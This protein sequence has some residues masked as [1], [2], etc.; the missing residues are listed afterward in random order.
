MNSVKEK[1]LGMRW[2][3]IKPGKFFDHVARKGKYLD[4]L[5]LMALLSV[6]I[7]IGLHTI[8][9]NVTPGM[10][11]MYAAQD[12]LAVFAALVVLTG[13]WGLFSALIGLRMR[14]RIAVAI[15]FKEA[16]P[17]C[18]R[19]V[20]FALTPLALLI[21]P[22]DLC[23]GLAALT[24]LVFSIV[25][26]SKAL[27]LKIMPSMI[28]NVIVL[29]SIIGA[30]WFVIKTFFVKPPSQPRQ[31]TA[32]EFEAQ[33]AAKALIGKPA[34]DI[35]I[36]PTGGTPL[37]LSDLKGKNVVIIDF[38]AIWC[39]PCKI[40]MPVVGEVAAQYKDKGVVFYTIGDGNIFQEKLYMEQ[41]RIDC[42]PSG[43]GL[44]GYKAFMVGPIPQT[45]IIGKD[46]IV[47]NVHIGLSSNM[48]EELTADLEAA[49]QEK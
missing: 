4:C 2:L 46:G 11:A 7:G 24:I 21:F 34:P 9:R 23:L 40:G 14:P 41:H 15:T 38:W 3:F 35:L 1:L 29:G 42:I 43:T 16:F 18:V 17:R 19:V 48:K 6:L 33:Y 49:L 45:V 37:H 10:V 47:K 44:P 22:A 26:V 20:S 32:Q 13:I 5:V 28:V 30:S 39:M 27:S 36:K 8:D 25:G 12:G 31:M